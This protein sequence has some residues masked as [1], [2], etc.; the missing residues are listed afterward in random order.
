MKPKRS[1]AEDNP[2]FRQRG[3][4]AHMQPTC[5]SHRYLPKPKAKVQP[6][7]H[8]HTV[9]HPAETTATMPNHVQSKP[10]PATPSS[11]L[12]GPLVTNCG[13]AAPCLR[14]PTTRPRSEINCEHKMTTMA[15]RCAFRWA[16]SAPMLAAAASESGLEMTNTGRLT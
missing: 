8:S 5:T 9:T 10:G 13:V 4:H 7:Y 15:A 11:Q 1:Q 3:V 14:K 12:E 2:T 16:V 6:L